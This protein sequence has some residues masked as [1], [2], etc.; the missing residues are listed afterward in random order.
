M[1]T[2]CHC[3]G[4]AARLAGVSGLCGRRTRKEG[5]RE[6]PG[7]LCW[8]HSRP[9]RRARAARCG[10]LFTGP[11]PLDVAASSDPTAP[12]PTRD[13]TC[14]GRHCPSGAL[15]LAA[16]TRKTS[17]AAH[18]P[19]HHNHH[20][21]R[22][23]SARGLLG[24][25]PWMNRR[26]VLSSQTASKDVH[27]TDRCGHVSWV[28]EMKPAWLIRSAPQGPGKAAHPGQSCPSCPAD[29]WL[30]PSR[31]PRVPSG[32]VLLGGH[33]TRSLSYPRKKLQ[34]SFNPLARLGRA[35]AAS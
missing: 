32:V 4:G 19:G 8:E 17:E 5:L 16:L 9:A 6:P 28:T 30:C 31:G 13:R 34:A 26:A 22:A 10:T 25:R 33:P 2:H 15:L 12:A 14:L 24:I 18:P 27:T 20:G 7:S 23:R 3:P 35:G 29:Q 21:G 1:K 11:S